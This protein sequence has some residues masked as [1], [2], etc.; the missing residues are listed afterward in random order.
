MHVGMIVR[1]ASLKKIFGVMNMV[2]V[3]GPI[4]GNQLT[5]SV[6]KPSYFGAVLGVT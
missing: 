5:V 1:C 4:R 3:A 2:M 6:M